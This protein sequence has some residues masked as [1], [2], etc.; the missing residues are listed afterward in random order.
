MRPF[1]ARL[2]SHG[3]LRA[4]TRASRRLDFPPRSF[5]RNAFSAPRA[6]RSAPE[7]RT[8]GRSVL[9]GPRTRRFE[10]PTR[11]KILRQGETAAGGRDALGCKRGEL[12]GRGANA[13]AN[14]TFA[15]LDSIHAKAD[16]VRCPPLPLCCRHCRP[17]F[18]PRQ[19]SQSPSPAA[20]PPTD[21]FL[22][23]PPFASPHC[24]RCLAPAR[25][26]RL[27]M[28]LGL[29]LEPSLLDRKMLAS[30]LWRSIV[31]FIT[32]SGIF[33]IGEYLR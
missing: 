9:R 16:W 23:P 5:P 4:N 10:G 12:A 28:Q 33:N 14:L 30:C 19:P 24:P 22:P 13:P 31:A 18:A 8:V 11:D 26:L 29:R 20:T 7:R 27:R 3:V 21:S 2:P 32:S 15:L 17:P 6:A 1:Q 25:R